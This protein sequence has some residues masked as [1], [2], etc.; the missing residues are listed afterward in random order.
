MGKP[1]PLYDPLDSKTEKEIDSI[2]SSGAGMVCGMPHVKNDGSYPSVIDL[3]S[4]GRFTGVSQMR[5]SK[6]SIKERRGKGGP[7]GPLVYDYTYAF[8]Y[9]LGRR[10]GASM[11]GKGDK[12]RVIRFCKF[13]DLEGLEG[14]CCSLMHGPKPTS[15]ASFEIYQGFCD[16]IDSKK[17]VRISKFDSLARSKPNVYVMSPARGIQGLLFVDNSSAK[18]AKQRVAITDMAFEYAKT[19]EHE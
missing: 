8:S 2:L 14:G 9:Y 11:A 5:G 13:G 17:L 19:M 12:V 7:T 10:V 3:W 6:M 15:V 18:T 1:V 4:N 16:G